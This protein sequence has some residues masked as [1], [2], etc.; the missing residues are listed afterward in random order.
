VGEEERLGGSGHHPHAGSGWGDGPCLLEKLLDLV[1]A[2]EVAEV[3]CKLG[4]GRRGRDGDM[5]DDLDRLGGVSAGA[6][7]IAFDRRD[8]RQGCVGVR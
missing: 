4:L 5:G 8:Q 7:P 1:E 2:T 6:L 3:A